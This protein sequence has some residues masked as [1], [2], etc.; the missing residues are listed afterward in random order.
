MKT[1]LE[2]KSSD[3]RERLFSLLEMLSRVMVGLET[4]CPLCDGVFTRE[5][6]EAHRRNRE[7]TAK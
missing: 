3:D 6:A 5:M 4:R 7:Q 1:C 2:K